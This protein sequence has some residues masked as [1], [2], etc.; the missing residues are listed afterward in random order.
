MGPI[1]ARLLP[2]VA[3]IGL[4]VTFWQQY[5]LQGLLVGVERLLPA[6]YLTKTGSYAP[7]ATISRRIVAIGDLHGDLDST[8][9][10]LRMAGLIDNDQV[11]NWVGG[12]DV[13][14]S[15]G[16]IIDRGDST[17]ELYRL[18]QRL[19]EQASLA[20]GAVLNCVS[21]TLLPEGGDTHS[22]AYN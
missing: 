5:R 1:A 13:F 18:F 14:I 20:G 12:H 10:I 7:I 19:R 16:D 4:V 22:C 9:R 2:V 11:P 3:A 15:T 17:I 8:H 6:G 21:A